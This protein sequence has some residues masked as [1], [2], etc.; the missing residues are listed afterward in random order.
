MEG[1]R[2][3]AFYLAK[4]GQLEEAIMLAREIKDD[5]EAAKARM[6]VAEALVQ[7]AGAPGRAK[8]LLFEADRLFNK[9]Q[10]ETPPEY[11]MRRLV[12]LFAQL[13]E[14]EKTMEIIRSAKSRRALTRRRWKKRSR[15]DTFPTN[16]TNRELRSKSTFAE[17][18]SPPRS[19]RCRSTNEVHKWLPKAL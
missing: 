3:L 2:Y 11:N 8:V 17:S 13:N 5:L 1:E 14:Q 19:S 4:Q 15:W 12:R 6:F 16:S 7:N 18:A 10:G 9:K